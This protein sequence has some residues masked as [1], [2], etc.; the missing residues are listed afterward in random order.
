[1]EV[2]YRCVGPCELPSPPPPPGRVA[3]GQ[4]GSVCEEDAPGRTGGHADAHSALVTWVTEPCLPKASCPNPG[5]RDCTTPCGRSPQRCDQVRGR[6]MGRVP[7]CSSWAHCNRQV[8]MRGKQEGQGQEGVGRQEQG[9]EK[10]RTG[11]RSKGCRGP[12]G[13]RRGRETSSP[14]E[15]PEGT[16]PAHTQSWERMCCLKPLVCGSLGDSPRRRR[17]LP[18]LWHSLCTPARTSWGAALSQCPNRPRLLG[19]A[20]RPLA[21]GFLPFSQL[22]LSSLVFLF[23]KYRPASGL[24]CSLRGVFSLLWPRRHVSYWESPEGRTFN[25]AQ[26]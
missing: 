21:P 25:D 7:W 20:P 3:S 13:A 5:R 17:A 12:P 8:S 16:S 15:L 14:Q 26:S 2:V 4:P 22:P 9:S 1:M 10:Q 11:P 19:V 24:F 23:S 18:W 6:E